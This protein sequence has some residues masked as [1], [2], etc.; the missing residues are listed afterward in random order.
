MTETRQAPASERERQAGVNRAA[1]ATS[2][3]SE[4]ML[5]S[6]IDVRYGAPGG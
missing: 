6:G 5:A 3:D 4:S 2:S 1:A